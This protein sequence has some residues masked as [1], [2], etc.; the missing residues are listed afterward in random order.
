M[1]IKIGHIILLIMTV[2]AVSCSKDD[3]QKQTEEPT[4]VADKTI[5]FSGTM[6]EET[7]ITRAGLDKFKTLFTVFGYKNTAMDGDSYTDYQTVFPGYTVNWAA[8]SA[9]TTTTNSNN[10]EY[11]GQELL[12]QPEQTAKYWDWSV[13]AYRFFGI[14]KTYD[15]IEGGAAGGAFNLTFTVDLTTDTGIDAVPYYSH[16][17]FSNNNYPSYPQYGL[18]VELKFL[19]PICKV[20]IMFVYEDPTNYDRANTPL[21][22]ISFHRTDGATIKQKGK[23]IISYPLTGTET[24]ETCT[25]DKG[26]SGILGFSRDY[27]EDDLN[28]PENEEDHFSYTVLPITGQGTFTLDVT[29]DG[30]PKQ[31]VVPAQFMDW[32]PGNEY[33]YIF[34]IHVDGSV[35][36]DNVQS[37]FTRW[38]ETSGNH[39]V[40]NW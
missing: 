25:F 14:T 35:T 22:D 20:R 12:G 2:L 36:I 31:T 39:T 29:V 34:K 37:A 27:R 19:R 18:P 15:N 13:K 8:N 3:S 1:K 38:D 16:L 26:A 7:V 23:V 17:W 28:T 5:A 11:V 6:Q 4:P 10:W 40:Y 33:T 30:D 21:E 32:K 24:A 9:A